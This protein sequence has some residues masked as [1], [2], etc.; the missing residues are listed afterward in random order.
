MN[1]IKILS[2]LFLFLSEALFAS[3]AIYS[4]TPLDSPIVN[5]PANFRNHIT[6]RILNQTSQTQTL[7]F[8][9]HTGLTQLVQEG[10]CTNPFTLGPNESCNLSLYVDGNVITES[11]TLKAPK[12]CK[13]N[14][15]FFCSFPES[16]N[17]IQVN[18]TNYSYILIA[19]EFGPFINYCQTGTSGSLTNCQTFTDANFS[20]PNGIAT[21]PGFSYAANASSNNITIC[22][23]NDFPTATCSTTDGGGVFDSPRT[24]YIHNGYFYT[25]NY[26]N[27]QV[28]KCN[29]NASTGALSNCASTGSGF[30]KPL[31]SMTISNGYAY[32]PNSSGNTQ[33]IS[34]CAVSPQDGSLSSCS[35]FSNSSFS[36]PSGV[37]VSGAYAYIISVWNDGV[38]ACVIDSTTGGLSDCKTNNV[39][40]ASTP[41]GLTIFNGYLYVNAHSPDQVVKCTIGDNG[42]VYDCGNTGSG[43]DGP[44][45]NITVIT[46]S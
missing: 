17:W 5:V 41:S 22:S 12:V 42:T 14:S 37:A 11:T 6:Y 38:V 26:N 2:L 10:F 34:I 30:N 24:A 1:F 33:N 19:S 36:S 7:S 18:I 3:K 40:T 21:I 8:Q 23:F 43:F 39:L 16:A 46:S 44:T 45:G 15:D 20:S 4:I 32:I 13:L 9:D 29:V 27:S 28:I 35:T 31:G 25:L